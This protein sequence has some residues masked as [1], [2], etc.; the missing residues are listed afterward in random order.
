M[1]LFGFEIGQKNV[2]N[3]YISFSRRGRDEQ[4]IQV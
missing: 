4:I 3:I 1:D 2:T